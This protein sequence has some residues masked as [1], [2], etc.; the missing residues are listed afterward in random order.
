MSGALL[1]AAST[2]CCC[3]HVG[4]PCS[5]PNRS[6]AIADGQISAVAVSVDMTLDDAERSNGCP[7]Q[8]CECPCD[9]VIAPYGDPG[10]VQYAYVSRGAIVDPDFID[11]TECAS[12]G[13]KPACCG[14]CPIYRCS[15]TFDTT[16]AER[17]P[18]GSWQ[19]IIRT[20]QDNVRGQWNW[21][22]T[23]VGYCNTTTNPLIRLRRYC[24]FSYIGWDILNAG[25]VDPNGQIVNPNTG[26]YT[27]INV[28]PLLCYA[29]VTVSP[30]GLLGVPCHY[31]AT[32]TLGYQFQ[33]EV[34]GAI[35]AG[36]QP[37]L[38]EPITATYLKPCTAPSDTVLGAY[39]LEYVPDYDF[40][41]EDQEC[42]PIRYFK[43]RRASF[44]QELLVA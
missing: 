4:C 37:E 8:G 13:C 9:A 24:Y 2:G 33:Q 26:E 11:G 44:P 28:G 20:A 38:I 10:G 22:P 21:L 27:G 25:A 42:G 32:V 17:Q 29:K 30:V 3:R 35:L 7:Y 14:G 36:Q 12:F 31:R 40:Y 15:S 5:D 39:S 19:S 16:I 43:E 34:V 41:E 23:Q 1:A 6:G 18:D